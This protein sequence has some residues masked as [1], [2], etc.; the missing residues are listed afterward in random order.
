MA[1]MLRPALI[2][3]QVTSRTHHPITGVRF[4]STK[5]N[6]SFIRRNALNVIGLPVCAFLLFFV[7][8]TFRPGEIHSIDWYDQQYLKQEREKQEQKK[9][10]V[11]AA[12]AAGN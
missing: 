7:L 12:T 9:S 10:G 1:K 5:K 4:Y 3:R 8:P 6:E 11:T 2:L